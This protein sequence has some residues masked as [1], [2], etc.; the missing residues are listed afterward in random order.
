[1]KIVN[2]VAMTFRDA[3]KDVP[4]LTLIRAYW[5]PEKKYASS[6]FAG[7][8]RTVSTLEK[9]AFFNDGQLARIG[10]GPLTM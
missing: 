4:G 5:L 10:F 3:T 8:G 2:I 7:L 1:M 9:P 6:L